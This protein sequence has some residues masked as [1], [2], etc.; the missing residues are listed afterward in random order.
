MGVFYQVWYNS[1]M[2]LNNT[3]LYQPNPDNKLTQS[4]FK[5]NI[6]GLL[7]IE[8][9]L[10]SDNRGFFTQLSIVPEIEEVSGLPFNIKQMN[11]SRSETNVIR[12][13][14]AESWNKLVTVVSGEALCVLVDIRPESHTFL[15]KEYFKMGK[16]PEANLC[17]SLFIPANLGNSICVLSGPV[18]Y[19]Y[20]VDQLYQQRKTTEDQAISLF[21]PDINVDWPVEKDDMIISQRDQDA[22]TLRQLLPDKFI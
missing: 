14:H 20:A 4:I 8:N 15:V 12:G 3:S 13:F 21:D 18:N 11:L 10:Y 17:G 7:Y 22:I 9:Q 5:T 6:D 2:L 16:D 19:I 1:P